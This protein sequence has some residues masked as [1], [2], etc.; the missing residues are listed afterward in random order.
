MI[1]INGDWE[2]R[3]VWVDGREITPSAAPHGFWKHGDDFAWGYG[4]S[5][6]AQLAL[7]ILLDQVDQETAL[8][9][10]QAFKWDV[11]AKLP[12]GDFELEISVYDWLINQVR[13]EE[14]RYK[15]LDDKQEI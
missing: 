10:Y 12:Q 4:G 6:P 9:Y 8:A 3:K 14:N 7:T 2:T 13:F 11:I 15:M 5:G 1:L